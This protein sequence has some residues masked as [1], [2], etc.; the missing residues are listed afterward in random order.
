M[1][2]RGYYAIL[3][4]A[5]RPLAELLLAAGPCALQ[6]R[7]KEGHSTRQIL[8]LGRWLAERTRLAGIPLIINDRVDVAVELGAAGVHLGQSDVPL[9]AAKAIGPGLWCGVS[10]HSLEQVKQACQAGADYIGFGPIFPTRTKVNPD[11]VV[12]IS[13]LEQAV[14]VSSVPVVAIGGITVENAGQVA[15]AGAAAACVISAVNDASHPTRAGR[16]VDSCWH[17]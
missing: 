8:E 2:L 6:L 10:T 16:A 3:D 11:P 7:L 5:S 4:R 15:T 13:G 14:R 17:K 9:A 12:G 1:K